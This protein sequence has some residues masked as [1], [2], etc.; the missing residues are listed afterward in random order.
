MIHKWNYIEILSQW[1]Y[2]FDRSSQT[3]QG[4]NVLTNIGCDTECMLSVSLSYH[5]APPRPAIGVIIW[6]DF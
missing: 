3:L 6:P 4:V 5:Q 2:I 1:R